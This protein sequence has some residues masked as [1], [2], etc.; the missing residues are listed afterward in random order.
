MKSAQQ[1]GYLLLLF[2]LLFFSCEKN[3]EKTDVSGIVVTS[4]LSRFDLEFY[5]SKDKDLSKIKDK[6]P[7]LFPIGTPDSVWIRQKHDSLSNVLLSD[8]KETFGDFQKEKKEID[9][10]FKHVKYY[11]SK[12]RAPHII[13]LISNLDL[14]NQVIYADSLLLISVDTYLGAHKKYYANYPEYLRNHFDKKHITNDI[15]TSIAYKIKPHL[16]YRLF[17]EKMISKAK[18]KYIQHLFL[19]DKKPED[20][21]EFT[22]EKYRWAVA[23]ERMVWQ[24][25]VE[26][27]YIYNTDKELNERFLDVA[28]FSKF[29]M[30]FDNESPGQIGV[31][32]GYQIIAS[33]MKNNKVSLPDMLATSPMI[34]FKNSKYKPTE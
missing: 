15:A 9:L 22:E 26:K 28:P 3:T 29:Y 7:Y 21:M 23:N 6:Y 12:F 25:F 8:V 10:L 18:T 17:V 2:S 4:K 31:W 13:T 24:Y 16:P 34:I 11:Y 1:T 20:I 32:I 5:E 14:D 19:P 30:S 33:Y 27:E